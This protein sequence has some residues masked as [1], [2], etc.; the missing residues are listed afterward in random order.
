MPRRR[1]SCREHTPVLHA[2]PLKTA[3]LVSFK[4]LTCCP[5]IRLSWP[6]TTLTGLLKGTLTSLQTNGAEGEDAASAADVCRSNWYAWLAARAPISYELRLAVRSIGEC[7][8]A[9][10]ACMDACSDVACWTTAVAKD[11]ST[12]S[13]STEI[14]R[15]RRVMCDLTA[16]AEVMGLGI[17]CRYTAT[18]TTDHQLIESDAV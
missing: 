6:A 12:D 1:C 8:S 5:S 9:F 4:T 14:K 18:S 11:G 13:S 2:A 17:P 16:P 15:P 10:T 3:A 7:T